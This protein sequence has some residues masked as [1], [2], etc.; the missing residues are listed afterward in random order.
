VLKTHRSEAATVRH[1]SATRKD[2][3]IPQQNLASQRTIVVLNLV[4]GRDAHTRCMHLEA[5]RGTSDGVKEIGAV[6]AWDTPV[7]AVVEKWIV[8]VDI[9]VEMKDKLTAE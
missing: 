7:A 6:P 4:G 8:A 5:G 9:R 1:T 3:A 2:P